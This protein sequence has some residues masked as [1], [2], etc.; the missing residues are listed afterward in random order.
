M[1]VT[2]GR[3][4]WTALIQTKI[5][6]QNDAVCSQLHTL[7]FCGNTVFARS[8]ANPCDNPH[9]ELRLL[10]A[11]QQH[12]TD[13]H[14]NGAAK[15]LPCSVACRNVARISLESRHLRSA[16]TPIRLRGFRHRICRC[17]KSMP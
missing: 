5:A 1:R 11:A 6:T 8:G 10:D 4:S 17:S 7:P 3:A 15:E 12:R 2:K 9:L 13:C 16:H 14:E